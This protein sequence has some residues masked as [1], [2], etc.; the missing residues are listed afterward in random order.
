MTDQT[1]L[2]GNPAAQLDLPPDLTAQ[3][4]DL[5][6]EIDFGALPAD[7][8]RR[9]R[10]SLADTVG[11]QALGSVT[12]PVAM[13]RR[14]VLH[15]VG[16]GA[17]VIG[18][19][20]VRADPLSAA[21]INGLSGHIR[22]FDDAGGGGHVSAIIVPVILALGETLDAAGADVMAA[23]MTGHEAAFRIRNLLT[24]SHYYLGFHAS[25]TVGTFGATAA[26]CRMLGLPRDS[27]LAAFGIA[28]SMAA[29]LI[30]NFGS[31]TKPLHT[32]NAARAG[33]L[34]ARLAQEGFTGS[35]EILEHQLGFARNHTLQVDTAA[36][37][38]P[39]GQPWSLSDMMYKFNA[40]CSGTH[41][42]G[43]GTRA[44]LREHN[45]AAADVAAMTLRVPKIQ[46]EVANIQ[47]PQTVEQ[48]KFSIRFVAAAGLLG[49]N[50]A[51]AF[52]EQDSQ[53]ADPAVQAA[54]GLIEVLPL[55]GIN[56]GCR[57]DIEMRL[58]NGQT[59]SGSF[60]SSIPM[61]DLDAEQAKIADKFRRTAGTLW[62]AATVDTALA[63]L[64]AFEHEPSVR[65]FLADLTAGGP[66]LPL[67]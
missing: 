1:T 37:L 59:V 47:W 17:T 52:P 2:T 38:A 53:I 65:A 35:P 27:W 25:G 60:D 36:A 20:P 40:A 28:G 31:M 13:L 4:I 33:I 63:R 16:D 34:A 44:L 10:H 50:T 45:L 61:T 54:I 22:D 64:L 55:D 46:T 48:A 5:V 39:L 30:A 8:Q 49:I 26:A 12:A 15:P 21:M 67:R 11:V 23:M 43:D 24:N 9:A 66:M 41:S 42:G 57:A 14:V 32:A 7:V 3:L 58:T 19:E 6:R 29:G 18:P 51:E 62:P 56:H